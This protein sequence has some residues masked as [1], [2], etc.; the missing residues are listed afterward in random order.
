MTWDNQGRRIV[1]H[2]HLLSYWRGTLE[3]DLRNRGM[4]PDTPIYAE[5]FL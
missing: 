4:M 5:D 2:D 3:R 1:T